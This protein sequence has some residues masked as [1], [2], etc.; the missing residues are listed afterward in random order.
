MWES[1]EKQRFWAGEDK[2]DFSKVV[3]GVGG[4]V[5]KESITHS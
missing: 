4:G 3:L 1:D 2:Q 5:F